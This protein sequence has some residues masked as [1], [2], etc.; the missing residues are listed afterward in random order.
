MVAATRQVDFESPQGR[1]RFDPEKPFGT[2]DFYIV[3]VVKKDG[4][5]GYEVVDV[6]KE[7]KPE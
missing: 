2:M 1:F 5:M 4:K 7:V 3:K 6:L